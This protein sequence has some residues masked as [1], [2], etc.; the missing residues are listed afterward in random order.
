MKTLK[1]SFVLLLVTTVFTTQ[2]LAIESAYRLNQSGEIVDDRVMYSI[3]GGSVIGAPVTSLRPWSYGVGAS[4]NSNFM[5]GNFDLQ[6]TIRNQ[7]NGLVDG[8]KDIMSGI[9]SAA[10]GAVA[11][12]PAMILQRANPGLYELISN[13]IMQARIDFD[14]SKLTCENMAKALTDA[15]TSSEWGDISSGQYFQDIVKWGNVDAISTT[16]N[17]EANKGQT[18]IEWMD[19]QRKGGAGQERIK[20]VEDVVKAGYNS[21]HRRSLTDNGTVST[22]SCD[23]GSVCTT[24]PTP[25]S[26]TQWAK[27]VL[28]ENEIATC[29]NCQS[30]FSVPGEGLTTLIQDTYVDKLKNIEGLL[31][32]SL[33]TNPTN[34]KNAS[35]GMLPVSR[36]VIE[37]LRDDPD[38]QVLSR[39]LA[40]EVAMSDVLEKALMLQRMLQA[41]SRAPAVES[42]KPAQEAV[43]KQLKNLSDEIASLK[44][45]MEIRQGLAMNTASAVLRR[46]EAGFSRSRI[47]ESGDPDRDRVL[48]MQQPVGP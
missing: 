32:G 36:R 40:S 20:I 46:Q 34:L 26:A 33:Q 29:Q 6:M 11:S 16:K 17:A 45:E 18:G 38:R 1:R 7:L 21:L 48:R 9:M 15:A 42:A 28:G 44:L 31:S 13:G 24:W 3:G 30:L 22:S 8:F 4:W 35:S 43:N 25:A 23:G 19:G 27:R 12:L 41:G 47:I 2:A 14:R 37:A 39:R 10:T 5:C